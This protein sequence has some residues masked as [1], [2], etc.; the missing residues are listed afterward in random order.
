M[1][2]FKSGVVLVVSS[3]VLALVTVVAMGPRCDVRLRPHE[4]WW[5]GDHIIEVYMPIVGLRL[6][7]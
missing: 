5:M 7:T 4:E 1:K 3:L 2:H 6:L